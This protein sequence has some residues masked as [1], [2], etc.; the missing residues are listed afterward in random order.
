M[1]HLLTLTMNQGGG[2]VSFGVNRGNARVVP[3]AG[4]PPLGG[5]WWYHVAQRDNKEP[6]EER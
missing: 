1:T 5:S 3:D 4:T 6:M 2:I